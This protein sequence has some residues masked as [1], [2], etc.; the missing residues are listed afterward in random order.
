MSAVTRNPT[1]KDLIQT[2]KFRLTFNRLPEV[3]FFCQSANI[4][5]VS[6]SEVPFTTPF[7]DLF[8][9]GEKILYDTFNIT[10]LIDEDLRSWHHLHDWIRAM[11]FPKEFEEYQALE[12]MNPVSVIR[13][14]TKIPPQ[15][16][17]GTLT[18]YSNKNNPMFRVQFKDL[19]PIMVGGI[20]F[21]TMDSAENVP[22]SDASFRFSRYDIE[23][24]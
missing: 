18:I 23:R 15:Y 3:S 13:A 11:T 19:F 12:R 10:F 16:S 24:I 6:L 22:V 20:L 8:V 5:G 2:N 17:D 9:P 4:P 14:Q 1:I 7:I 21:N